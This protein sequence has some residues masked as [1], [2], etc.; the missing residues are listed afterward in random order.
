MF[1]IR[2]QDNIAQE[3]VPEFNPDFPGI[4]IEQRYA[5]DFL[6]Q[7]IQWHEEVQQGWMYDIKANTVS[8]PPDSEAD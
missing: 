6:A 5:P 1:F 2:T 7:C 3:S 4:P 8:P